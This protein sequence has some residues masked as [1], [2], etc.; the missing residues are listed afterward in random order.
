VAGYAILGGVF[1]LVSAIRL[2]QGL[3]SRGR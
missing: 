2:H 3:G 1:F